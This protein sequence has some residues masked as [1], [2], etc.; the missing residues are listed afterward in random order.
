MSNTQPPINSPADIKLVFKGASGLHTS[1]SQTGRFRVTQQESQPSSNIRSD[2]VGNLGLES[3]WRIRYG[4][5]IPR[6]KDWTSNALTLNHSKL[7]GW[8]PS[9]RLEHSAR[10]GY[11]R[12]Q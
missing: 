2:L 5:N 11:S 8:L 6:H 9:A 12:K 7:T 1:G 10:G 4:V 3:Q